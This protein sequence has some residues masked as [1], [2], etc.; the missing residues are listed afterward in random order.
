MKL[1]KLILLTLI[2]LLLTNCEDSSTSSTDEPTNLEIKILLSTMYNYNLNVT[3]VFARISGESYSDS[4]FL[5][6]Q[7]SIFIAVAEFTDIDAGDYNIDYKIFIDADSI[8]VVS[9]LFACHVYSNVS[10]KI[11][12]SDYI[13]NLEPTISL[14][15]GEEFQ[16]P[17]DVN[18][19]VLGLSHETLFSVKIIADI[20]T[21]AKDIAGINYFINQNNHGW[22]LFKCNDEEPYDLKLDE[23]NWLPNFS[24]SEIYSQ[25][26]Y[27]DRD[28]IVS[29]TIIYF[30]YITDYESSVKNGSTYTFRF[31]PANPYY[32]FINIDRILIAGDFYGDFNHDYDSPYH[33][34][35]QND[36]I[37]EIELSEEYDGVTS[38]TQYKFVIYWE[39]GSTD[40]YS[41]IA[42]YRIVSD[43]FG[44][45][46]S[47]MP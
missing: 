22:M 24:F 5:T 47:V 36:G 38:G 42:N 33:L 29:D 15:Y 44:G 7:D 13:I 45:Y 8:L 35:Q 30:S 11:T 21:W 19:A 10:N 20:N 17:D 18:Y 28:V 3:G 40:W 14:H 27:A 46:N 4:T 37:Y 16:F 23:T 1:M 43:G 25:L 41:D 32:N 26:F 31:D 2:V 6:I 12:I 34:I 9:E 39:N